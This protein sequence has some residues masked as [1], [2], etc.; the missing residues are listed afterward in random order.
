ME[1]KIW[2]EVPGQPKGKARARTFYNPNLR[3]MQ[4]VTPTNTVLYE[5]WIKEC[6]IK[7]A[8]TINHKGFFGKEALDVAINAIYEI[9]KSTSKK[10]RQKMESGELLPCKKPDADN[11]AKVICDALNKVAYGDDT[12]ICNLYVCKRYTKENEEACVQV[13]IFTQGE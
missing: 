5:N 3:R 6:Y 12:Q 7:Q 1:R 2:F 9:P 13:F 10:N 11:I 8:E 4:S